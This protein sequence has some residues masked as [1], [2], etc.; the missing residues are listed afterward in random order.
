MRSASTS[1]GSL[2]C[3]CKLN[4]VYLATI[5]EASSRRVMRGLAFTILAATVFGNGEIA[6]G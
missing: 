5:L 6:A 3:G 4:S 2:A 1:F